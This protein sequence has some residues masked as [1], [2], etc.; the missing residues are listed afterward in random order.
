MKTSKVKILVSINYFLFI[1]FNKNY[2]LKTDKIN[3]EWKDYPRY[4]FS[5]SVITKGIKH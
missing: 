4:E 3:R 2:L 5:K 1:N